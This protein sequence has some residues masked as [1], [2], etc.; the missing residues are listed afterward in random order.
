MLPI[1]VYVGLV[2]VGGGNRSKT[3]WHAKRTALDSG[4]DG[5]MF[6]TTSM[7]ASRP[8]LGRGAD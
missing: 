2:G 7:V 6:Q 5:K 4:V 3:T 1:K 8:S